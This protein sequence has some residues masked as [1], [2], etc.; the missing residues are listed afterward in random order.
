MITILASNDAI[1]WA[2]TQSP[3]QIAAALDIGVGAMIAAQTHVSTNNLA[4]TAGKIGEATV[5]DIL[6]TRFCAKNVSKTAH[7]G[8]ISLEVGQ[9]KIMIE[10]KNYTNTVP[11]AQVDK[12]IA[13]LATSASRGGV[14][15]ALNTTIAG[16]TSEIPQIVMR[17]ELGNVP[18]A[19]VSVVSDGVSDAPTT[20]T[21]PATTIII[22]AVDMVVQMIHMRRHIDIEC[23]DK[24]PL[25]KAARFRTRN[26]RNHSG[27]C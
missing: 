6:Q 17:T 22:A 26:R 10:V 18:C 25:N 27:A 24:T 9:Q 12:F 1:K 4:V 5:S 13:D 21:T 23:N 2:K 11:S 15:I 8:D 7:S 20:V 19:Y 14:F 16:V 3:E